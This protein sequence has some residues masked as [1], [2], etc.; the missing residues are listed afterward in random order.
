MKTL[1]TSLLAVGVLGVGAFAATP[2]AKMPAKHTAMDKASVT[3]KCPS[4]HMAM[5]MHKSAMYPV[6]VKHN[7]KTFYCCTQCASGKAAMKAMKMKPKSTAKPAA[8]AA[9][10]PAK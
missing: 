2:A 10:K 4:C 1:F 6:P 8:K 7:G 3:L 5:P 9:A